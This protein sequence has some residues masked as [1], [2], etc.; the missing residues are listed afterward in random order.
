MPDEDSLVVVERELAVLFRRARAFSTLLAREFHPEL[1][2]GAYALLTWLDDVGS[3]RQTE[4]AAFFGVGKPTLSRQINLLERLNLITRT[5]DDTDRRAQRLTLTP[6]G[7]ARLRRVTRARRERFRTLLD[8]WPKQDIHTLG[9]LLGRFNQVIG[10]AGPEN[11]T[12]ADETEPNDAEP[13]DT[14]HASDADD[15]TDQPRRSRCRN[16]TSHRNST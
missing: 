12:E 2:S 8:P 13:S 15:T 10:T 9:T 14:D 4:M 16:S 1:E 3:A 6:D 5:V 7:S 11:S